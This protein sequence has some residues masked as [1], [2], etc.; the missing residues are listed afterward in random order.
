M[1]ETMSGTSAVGCT[2]AN[3]SVRSKVDRADWEAKEEIASGGPLSSVLIAT[4][5][6]LLDAHT[7]E[8]CEEIVYTK[9]TTPTWLT[10]IEEGAKTEGVNLKLLIPEF[11]FGDG[12]HCFFERFG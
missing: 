7:D 12:G 2:T 9:S 6:V 4:E 10:L 3:E 5:E 11:A 1:T 8:L